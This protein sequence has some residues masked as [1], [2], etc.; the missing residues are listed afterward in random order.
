[1]PLVCIIVVPL[2]VVG[3]DALGE[4]NP[5]LPRLLATAAPRMGG[6]DQKYPH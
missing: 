6:S 3:D 4:E 1:V 2:L 5:L